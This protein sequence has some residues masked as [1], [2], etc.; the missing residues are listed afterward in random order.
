M[1]KNHFFAG[2]VKRIINADPSLMLVKP[3]I[4]LYMKQEFYYNL[5]NLTIASSRLI[6]LLQGP[7]YSAA[8]DV[9]LLWQRCPEELADKPIFTSPFCQYNA[10]EW[11]FRLPH[12]GNFYVTNGNGIAIEMHTAIAAETV[13][14]LYR[15]ALPVLLYQRGMVC[16]DV[17]GIIMPNRRLLLIAGDRKYSAI[18]PLMSAGYKIFGCS[19]L[20]IT[21][22][23]NHPHASSSLP[24][25]ELWE[26]DVLPYFPE[27]QQEGIVVNGNNVKWYTN[28]EHTAT[29]KIDSIIIINRATKN[30]FEKLGLPAA[31]E[32]VSNCLP[33]LAWASILQEK[34]LFQFLVSFVQKTPCYNLNYIITDTDNSFMNHHLHTIIN[35]I[36]DGK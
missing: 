2:T 21:I 24:Y 7:P 31:M 22:I 8:A 15:N 18:L 16:L 3:G 36:E 27:R 6:P 32:K 5:F 30:S 10:Q 17:L 33:H 19:P 9:Q 29:L 13:L 14:Y 23:D 25:L 28:D 26:K 20:G 4:H 35:T 1:H 11:L 12:L 34:K